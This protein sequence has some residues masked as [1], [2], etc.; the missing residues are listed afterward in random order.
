VVTYYLI[1]NFNNQPIAV[2]VFQSADFSAK[3]FLS[4]M[5]WKD[6]QLKVGILQHILPILSW[7]LD[8]LFNRL[9]ICGNIFIGGKFGIHYKQDSLFAYNELVVALNRFI[10]ANQLDNSKTLILLKDFDVNSFSEMNDFSSFGYHIYWYIPNLSISIK[11]ESFNEY[12]EKL[13]SQYRNRENSIREQGKLLKRVSLSANLLDS[14][15]SRL[16]AL[17]DAVHSK[18]PNISK[19]NIPEH[20]TQ[21]KS[22]LPGN[23]EVIGYYLENQLVGFCSWFHDETNIFFYYPGLDYKINQKYKLYN[24]ILFDLVEAGITLNVQRVV[25][26]RTSSEIK[27]SVGAVPVPMAILVR[28]PN[29]ILNFILGLLIKWLN[30]KSPGFIQRHPFRD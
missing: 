28:H 30:K 24:N 27:S 4:N 22:S 18:Y 20:F 1:I 12:R 21:L 19:L 9:M 25:F 26:G 8:K 6:L 3:Q 29:R 17:Y 2:S 16:Q 14:E 5:R 13:R 15:R 7:A 23:F 10:E 11:W